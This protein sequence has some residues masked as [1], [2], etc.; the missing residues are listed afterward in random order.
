M[1]ILVKAALYTWPLVVIFL[2]TRLS[3][4][5]AVIASVIAGTLFLPEVQIAKV[6]DEAPDA[7]EFVLLILKFTKPNAI[8]FAA[9]LGAILFDLK[10]LLTYRP[11][12]FDIPIVIYCICPY[13]SNLQAGVGNYDSFGM[14]R[15]K[16]LSWG[17]PYFL[18][19]V[20]FTNLNNFRD[21]AVGIF[22]GGLVYAPLCLWESV[23]FPHLHE[24]AYGF[25]PG[26]KNEVFRWGGYRP[27]VFLSHGIMLGMWMTATA[28]IGFWLWFTGAITELK[29]WPFRRSISMGMLM[30]FLGLTTLWVRSTGAIAIGVAAVVGVLQLRL[31]KLPVILGFL[32]L[33]SPVYIYERASGW[34]GDN[35]LEALKD[36]GMPPE[37][38]G[39]LWYRLHMEN[40]LVL[41]YQKRPNFGYGDFKPDAFMAPMLK[42]NDY[43]R[44]VMDSMWIQ[45]LAFYGHY[46]LASMWLV[47]LLPVVR[48]ILYHP[49]RLWFNPALAPAAGVALVLIMYMI[50]NMFNAFANTVFILAAGAL[51]SLAGVRLPRPAPVRSEPEDTGVPPPPP[52]P[53]EHVRERR[54]GVLVR[55]RF[56]H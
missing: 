47:L 5:R 6:S 1:P 56:R 3:P 15:D 40:R 55:D 23:M 16:V 32:L 45:Q 33:V 20:Y 52:A 39:S 11:R 28:V 36:A 14:M 27:V 51:A 29:I 48:F 24:S 53:E 38:L 13:I 18:G 37:R 34:K 12:W 31:V 8:C 9:L 35:F 25:F 21:L 19:R 54:P 50:D 43:P 10:G 49:P 46:G 7:Y 2:F 26:P 30:L 22:L 42:T 41:H 4:H 44:A 17:V